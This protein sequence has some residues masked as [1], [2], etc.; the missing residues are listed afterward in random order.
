MTKTSTP[1]HIVNSLNSQLVEKVADVAEQQ[2]EL[3]YNS[4]KSQL[5]KLVKN[6]SDE[7][8]DKIL[9]YSKKK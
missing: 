5:N 2:D 6:P 7:T 4:I 3:F 8:I 9:A 1:T